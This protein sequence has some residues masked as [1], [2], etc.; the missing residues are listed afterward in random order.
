MTFIKWL[1][2]TRLWSQECLRVLSQWRGASQ[3]PCPPALCGPVPLLS[4]ASLRVH[5]VGLMWRYSVTETPL[6]LGGRSFLSRITLSGGCCAVS[7]QL[8]RP[9]GPDRELPAGSTKAGGGRPVTRSPLPP[10]C[11]PHGWP[12][13]QGTRIQIPEAVRCW[14]SCYA[15]VGNCYMEV[16]LLS[17]EKLQSL[18]W[19]TCSKSTFLLMFF[20]IQFGNIF[21]RMFT[22]LFKRVFGK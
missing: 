17:D 15:E 12:Q 18:P 13:P 21:F 7:G 8:E 9:Q 5:S 1:F 11:C 3:E 14:M 16:Q 6:H 4:R 10:D 2:E 20:W 19:F 22:F